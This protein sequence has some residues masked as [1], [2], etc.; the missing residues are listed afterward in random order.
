MI[1]ILK[2]KTCNDDVDLRE[3]NYDRK[4][5][6]KHKCNVL[7]RKLTGFIDRIANQLINKQILCRSVINYRCGQNEIRTKKVMLEAQS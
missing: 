5:N 1:I 6:D 7:K 2:Q 4:F 3:N